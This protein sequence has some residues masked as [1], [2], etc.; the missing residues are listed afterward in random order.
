M[1]PRSC[2]IPQ[3]REIFDS[4]GIAQAPHS[5]DA[6]THAKNAK[7]RLWSGRRRGTQRSTGRGE[8]G[9]PYYVPHARDFEGRP[10][11]AIFSRGCGPGRSPDR[12]GAG[13]GQ[14]W[15]SFNGWSGRVGGVM[16]RARILALE[17]GAGREGLLWR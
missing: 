13:T 2:G 5:R 6:I 16:V 14:V 3:A 15:Q 17:V 1:L 7:P 11:R 9:W 4:G 12:V 8:G 10:G